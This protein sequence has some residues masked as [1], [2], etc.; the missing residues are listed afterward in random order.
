MINGAPSGMSWLSSVQNWFADRAQ[1][2]GEV[3][4]L[5]LAVV[6][7]AIGIAVAKN[8]HPRKFLIAAIVLN[9]L[10]WVVG[11][12]F[13]GIFEGGATDPNAGPLFALLAVALYALVPFEA[14]TERAVTAP[15]AS[16]PT[17]A[18]Q[19]GG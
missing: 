10:Y 8:W 18:T 1:G 14:R 17:L 11:Q 13:G 4:A 6:T 12:G 3:I 9:L 19:P 16:V 7:A 2:N 5:I 15:A